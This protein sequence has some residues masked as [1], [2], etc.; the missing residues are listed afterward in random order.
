LEEDGK[1]ATASAVTISLRCYEARHGRVGVL[2]TNILAEHTQTLWSPTGAEF[3]PLG[4]LD[5]PFRLVIPVNTPGSSN[6]HLQEYRVY[7][8][9]EAGEYGYIVYVVKS[10]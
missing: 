6:F 2:K 8:R 1:S 9:L 3:G 5:L 7:W 10:S 4:E